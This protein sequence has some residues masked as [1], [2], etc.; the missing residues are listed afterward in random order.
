MYPVR[1]KNKT[2][3]FIDRGYFLKPVIGSKHM[4]RE[5]PAWAIDADAFDNWVKPNAREIIVTDT[6]AKIRYRVLVETFDRLK[7]ELDRGYGRQY[8]LVLSHWT[9]QSYKGEGNES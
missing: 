6:E 9:K 2:I 5:P 7:V 3:G 1:V 4:L 8:F